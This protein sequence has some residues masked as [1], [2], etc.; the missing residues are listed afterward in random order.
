LLSDFARDIGS[1][2]QQLEYMSDRKIND[3]E[4]TEKIKKIFLENYLRNAK[5][6]L[7]ENLRKRIDTYYNWTVLRTATHFLIKEEPETE[8]AKLL[9]EKIFKNFNLP[10]SS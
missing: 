4:Y 5:I 3:P 2:L 10:L 8:R 7:D 6:K 9:L 1:F